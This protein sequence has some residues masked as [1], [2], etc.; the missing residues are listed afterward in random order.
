MK[1]RK[2]SRGAAVALIIGGDLVLLALGWFLLVSPQRQTASSTALAVNSM[3]AQ[4]HE[5]QR[6]LAEPVQAPTA[7]KQ[8]AIRTA[9]LYRLAKA[10][11]TSEDM[12]DLLLE[13]DQ[14][15]RAAGVSIQAISPSTPTAGPGYDIVPIGLTFTGDFYAVTD[16]LYR[17]RTLVSVRHGALDAS[18]RLFAVN[19]VGLGPSGIG[20]DLAANV[21]VEAYIY[22]NAAT[23]A[24]AA[25][26]A[27]TTTSSTTTG[28]TTTTSAADAAPAP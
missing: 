18:G 11:P 27:P 24:G 9:D 16:M 15:A 5:A 21:Q 6:Q 14:V 28:D 10:M 19:N 2:V 26:V 12:P 25:A 23:S 3:Q 4:L 13:L 7:P 20:K 8:P 17:L 1:R 22:G